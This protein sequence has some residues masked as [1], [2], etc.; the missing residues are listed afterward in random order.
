VSS[1]ERD[2]VLK[3][4]NPKHLRRDLQAYE[5]IPPTLRNRYFAKIYWKSKYCLLQKYGEKGHV[6]AERLT[7]LKKI[8]RRYGLTD[9]RPSNIRR[10]DG[11]FKI[12][13]AN[14]GRRASLRSSTR[15]R[16]R[17]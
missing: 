11:H 15:N 1:R 6:P 8:G 12:V 7:R 14:P 2:L 10:V 9:I 5:R 13:D 17:R 4:S 16:R 3:V